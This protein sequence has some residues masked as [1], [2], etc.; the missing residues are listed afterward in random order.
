MATN[1]GEA[2]RARSSKLLSLKAEPLRVGICGW[3][4]S[5][6]VTPRGLNASFVNKLLSVEGIVTKATHVNARMLKA[7]Y[8]ASNRDRYVVVEHPDPISVKPRA[9]QSA[10]AVYDLTRDQEGALLDLE[11]GLSHF[12]NLQVI[13]LQEVPETCPAGHLPRS[14]DVVCESDLV[15]CCT[16]GNR[17]C[18]TGVLR[19]ATNKK[20]R[21]VGSHARHYIVANHLAQIGIRHVDTSFTDAQFAQLKEIA[22]HPRTLTLLAHSI[23]PSICGHINIRKALALQLAGGRSCTSSGDN[24]RLRGDIHVLLIGDPSC[25][26]SQMLRFMMKLANLSISTT[27]RGS[28]AVGLTAAVIVD[29]ET[30][31][32]RLEA[33]AMVLADGGLVCIDEFDKMND[34]DRV[35]VHE[36][37]E[38][39]SVS[40]NKAGLSATLNARTS[41]LAAAN[42]LHGTFN[43]NVDV[44]K[45]VNFPDSLLSRFDLI[46]YVLES[47]DSATDKR[48]ARQVLAQMRQAI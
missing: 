13:T 34:D 5:R 15:D 18:V 30:G 43:Q 27:G 25:G 46:F 24:I 44:L 16:P 47:L 28:S 8:F 1:L 21:T 2:Q 45:Q 26:K 35:A 12:R 9:L 38:Q 40:I 10:T 11:Y 3:L 36:I 4:G 6:S 41:V 42:P 32:R 33:G 14:I 39:Q 37:M 29:P 19:C 17:V 22:E 7:V 31:G 48:I 20:Q 23:C